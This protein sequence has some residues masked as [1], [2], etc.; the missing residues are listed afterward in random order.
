MRK[1]CK[2]KR[3]VE[4]NDCSRIFLLSPAYAG[5]LRAQMIFSERAQFDLARRLHNWTRSPCTFLARPPTR[6]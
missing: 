1:F 2:G 4:R 5:G 6:V 3:D